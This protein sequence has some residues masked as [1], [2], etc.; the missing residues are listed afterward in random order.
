[1]TAKFPVSK[2]VF[3]AVVTFLCGMAPLF[4]EQTDSHTDR[5]MQATGFVTTTSKL[6]LNSDQIQ[7]AGVKAATLNLPD[8]A[9]VAFD[10]SV[11]VLKN[12][13]HKIALNGGAVGVGSPMKMGFTVVREPQHGTLDK[14]SLAAGL[15]TYVPAKD[16]QGADSFQFNID[17]GG[18]VTKPATVSLQVVPVK[19]AASVGSSIT[20]GGG[21]VTDPVTK[22]LNARSTAF[23]KE[24][25]DKK[26]KFFEDLRAKDLSPDE[27]RGKINDF[28]KDELKREQKFRLRQ[29][30]FLEKQGDESFFS[31]I[32]DPK[33][34]LDDLALFFKLREPS[35]EELNQQ[36]ADFI[37]AQRDKRA[38]FIQDLRKDNLTPDEKSQKIKDFNDAQV[39][40]EQEFLEK[41]RQIIEKQAQD[42]DQGDD[43]SD[44]DVKNEISD[45][46][47]NLA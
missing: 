32:F 12:V 4:A 30:K 23:F 20:P 29:Q 9:L 10:Q 15:L 44:E 13:S 31:K 5:P 34:T 35:V 28:R 25:Q 46:F 24:E 2:F 21:L 17:S 26:R 18:A 38:K 1:M 6:I 27:M 22:E 14:S 41:R 37:A 43:R 3:A 45:F 8:Q 19:T 11:E 7:D 47:K 16:F 36:R 33:G 42:V 39:A 40:K